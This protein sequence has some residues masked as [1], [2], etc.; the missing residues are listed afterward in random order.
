MDAYVLQKSRS[1]YDTADKVQAAKEKD[2]RIDE[3]HK[4]KDQMIKSWLGRSRRTTIRT[5][6]DCK[7]QGLGN[8]MVLQFDAR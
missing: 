8:K 3:H 6:K 7:E 4:V 5:V 2:R 1:N